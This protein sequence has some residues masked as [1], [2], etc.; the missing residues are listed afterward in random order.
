[1]GTCGSAWLRTGPLSVGF[2]PLPMIKRSG[3]VAKE[4]A[5]VVA[6]IADSLTR[7]TGYV[8]ARPLSV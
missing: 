6:R 4:V 7:H 2:R 8:S 3:V 1:M 5:V